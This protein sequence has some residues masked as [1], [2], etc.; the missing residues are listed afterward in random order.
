MYNKVLCILVVTLPLIKFTFSNT[1]YTID[2]HIEILDNHIDEK[3]NKKSSSLIVKLTP[4][5][6][7]GQCSL[8]VQTV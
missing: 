4:H 6:E 1:T 5:E 7:N 8:V 3:D 2:N